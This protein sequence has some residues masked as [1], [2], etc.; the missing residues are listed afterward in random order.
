MRRDWDIVKKILKATEDL[1]LG[2]ALTRHSFPDEDVDVIAYHVEL[3]GEAGLIQIGLHHEQGGG[4]THFHIWRLTWEGH[5]FLDSIRNDS[6]WQKTKDTFSHQ[7]ISMSFDMVK[8]VALKLCYEA[9]D[10]V[11]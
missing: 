10:T 2:K 6:I 4:V 5:E 1:K 3:L 7:G 8:A 9:L 11:A